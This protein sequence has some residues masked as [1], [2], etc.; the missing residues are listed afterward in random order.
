MHGAW[1]DGDSQNLN[2]ASNALRTT[3]DIAQSAGPRAI[4]RFDSGAG[5]GD[6]VVG[7][8]VAQD[9]IK[10]TTL[11]NAELAVPGGA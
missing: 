8:V 2:S 7:H 5:V 6:G 11:S 3:S 4:A 1:C 10:E 9:L